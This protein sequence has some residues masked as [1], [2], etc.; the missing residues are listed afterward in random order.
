ME[1]KSKYFSYDVKLREIID[2]MSNTEWKSIETKLLARAKSESGEPFTSIDH[3]D[4]DD[5]TGT[6]SFGLST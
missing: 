3:V 2:L 4:T 5:N 6:V 1:L